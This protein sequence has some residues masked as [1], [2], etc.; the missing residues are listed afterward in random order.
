MDKNLPWLEDTII[1]IGADI[2]YHWVSRHEYR[3][4]LAFGSKPL[5]F[6]KYHSEY[7]GMF[8]ACQP[9]F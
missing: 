6:H 4:A 5:A 7:I 3:R 1:L 9:V 8:L 2:F